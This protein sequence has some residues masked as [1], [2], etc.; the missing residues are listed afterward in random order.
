MKSLSKELIEILLKYYLKGDGHVYGRTGKGVSATTTSIRLRDDLQEIALKVGIS[1]YYKLGR[2]KGRPLSSL[3]YKGKV[4]K[5]KE[6]AWVIYFTRRNKPIILPSTI[7]KHNYIESWV[8]YHGLVFCVAVPNQV[9]YV[10]RNGIPLWCG[11]SD[12]EMN[13]SLSSLDSFQLV[14][15]SDSHSPYPFRIGREANLFDLRSTTYDSLLEAIRGGEGSSLVMTIETFPEYGKYHWPGHRACNFSVSPDEYLKLKGTCPVCGRKLTN[16]VDLEV[17]MRADRPRGYMPKSAK[18]F[19]RVIP[20]SEL[21]SE[22]LAST[23]TSSKVWNLYKE[24]VERFGNEFSVLL[25]SPVEVIEEVGGRPLARS[26]DMMRQGTLKVKPGY[27]GQYGQLELRPR[28]K[29]Q[30]L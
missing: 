21:I 29:Q 12:P 24:L 25:H 4:Y 15:N 13:W 18:P 7:R 17:R 30:K 3:P 16:G 28:K 8:N 20:L 23:V 2:K 19:M 27:D 5:Q 11:N 22:T 1:A 14:S 6:D 26:I 9:V 10:R